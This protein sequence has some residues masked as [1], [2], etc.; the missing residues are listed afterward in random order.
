MTHMTTA[1]TKLLLARIKEM[2]AQGIE[3]LVL[4]TTSHA[5]AQN[6]VWGIP[7]SVAVMTNLTHEHLEYHRTFER[8]REAKVKMFRMAAA[9]TD[10]LR[11]GVVNA[12]D[13]SAPY[14][15]AAVPVVM[16]YSSKQAQ[17]ELVASNVKSTPGGNEFDLRFEDR[18]LHIKTS[19]PGSF[20]VENSVAAA[21]AGL[22]VGLTNEQVEKGIAALKSVEGRMTRIDEGQ[23]FEAIV[24]YAH[25]PDSFE[26]LFRDMKPIVKGR[27]IVVFGSQGRTGDVGKRAIQGKLAGEYADLVVITEEDDRGEDGNHILEQIAEGAAKG[28]KVRDRDMWLILDRT[29]AIEK[30][31]SLAKRGDAVLVLGK[32]HEKTI[33]R[34]A[35]GEEPWDEPGVVRKA[36]QDRLKKKAAN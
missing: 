32:G 26:K 19:L 23:D 16:R 33:E 30:G 14:F 29:K 24:D 12:D 25:S 17:A 2:K 11:T 34:H 22:A 1:G 27:L 35:Q 21:G 3:W 7:Y 8:Y 5:L 18:R 10:G 9:N 4:E 6:R 13:P 15:A 28:G 20:N 36:V 31:V